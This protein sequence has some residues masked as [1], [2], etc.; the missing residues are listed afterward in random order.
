MTEGPGPTSSPRSL[1]APRVTC[2]LSLVGFGRRQ[3]LT[4]WRIMVSHRLFF[5]MQVLLHWFGW[6]LDAS[7]GSCAYACSSSLRPTYACLST[8]CL[9]GYTALLSPRTSSVSP[10]PVLHRNPRH[11]H[12]MVTCQSVGVLHPVDRLILSTTA[13]PSASLVQSSVHSA[14]VDPHWHCVMEEEYQALVAN[15]T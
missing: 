6:W 15:H 8:Y 5:H 10:H 3:I 13:S 1:T 7:C 14:L 2:R 12:S 4:P 9:G 11:I